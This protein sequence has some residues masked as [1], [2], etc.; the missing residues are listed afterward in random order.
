[1]TVLQFLVQALG[2][3]LGIII[4]AIVISIF[5][6]L[7]NWARKPSKNPEPKDISYTPKEYRPHD[8]VYT[9]YYGHR[10]AGGMM[11]YEYKNLPNVRAIF[12]TTRREAEE[13]LNEL[14]EIIEAYGI[15]SVADYYTKTKMPI[16]DRSNSIGWTNLFKATVLRNSHGYLIDLPRPKSI[17]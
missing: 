9:S 1:M 8:V 11:F 10:S 16:P 12:F 7:W 14:L 15:V 17:D 4:A 2:I 5:E 3:A 6:A 13:V